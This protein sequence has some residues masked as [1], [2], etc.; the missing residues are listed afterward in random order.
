MKL[1][2]KFGILEFFIAFLLLLF[3]VDLSLNYH[4]E[5]RREKAV[6]HNYFEHTSQSIYSEIIKFSAPADEIINISKHFFYSGQLNIHDYKALNN[7]FMPFMK[8]HPYITSINLGDEKGNGYLIL[9]LGNLYKNRIKKWNMSGK[10]IWIYLNEIGEELKKE[11]VTDDYDPRNRPWYLIAKDNSTI[12]WS[13]PYVFRTTRDVGITASSNISF[14]KSTKIVIGLDIM[15]KDLSR[16]LFQINNTYKGANIKIISQD[17]K[18]IASSDKGFEEFLKKDDPTLLDL[19][20]KRDELFYNA[21]NTYNKNKSP[22]IYINLNGENYHVSVKQM[23]LSSDYKM[24]LFISLPESTFLINYRHS[25]VKKSLIYLVIL[26]IGGL[27]I[28]KRYLIPLRKLSVAI[29]DYP[30][31][32]YQSLSFVERHDEV[33]IIA[34]EFAKMAKDLDA[35]TNQLLLSENNYRLLFESNPL[36]FL[37]IDQETLQ[38]LKVNKAALRLY[39]A[40]ET[41]LSIL[42]LNDLCYDNEKNITLRFDEVTKGILKHKKLDGSP[43]FVEVHSNSIIWHNKEAILM[44][45]VDISQRLILEE[46]LLQAQNLQRIGILAG[47]IAHEFNNILA[48]ILGYASLMELK[49]DLH[50]PQLKNVREIIKACQKAVNLVN[51]MLA[52]GRKQPLEIKKFNLN[53]MINDFLPTIKTV[54]NNQHLVETAL[55]TTPLYVNADKNRLEHVLLNL[56]LNAKDAMSG[57]GKITIITNKVLISQE[58]FP[59]LSDGYYALIQ[60]S[61]NGAG[62]D[63][64]T[65]KHIFDPFFT[66]KEVGKGTGLG[67][68]VVYGIIKQHGGDISV[69]SS[70]GSGATFFIYLPLVNN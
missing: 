51:E 46:Q 2:F 67:L 9:R 35:K 21:Y 39:D 11:L 5:L 54:L 13:S 62:M 32:S 68:S 44:L 26:L 6:F 47:G 48:A 49:M 16:F 58:H 42:S 37:I 50:D 30:V 22:F 61:D 43:V 28:I 8:T 45:C 3:L 66:T 59:S 4:E 52:F 70:I 23:S 65:K 29:S 31:Q 40:S 63:E 1:K 17:S 57:R 38:I 15:L 60:F 19:T 10:V 12:N 34:N 69:E 55:S 18:I 25:A 53:D 7:F 33:G 24:F 36:P 56:A 41:Q 64:Y 20:A 14:D 27:I